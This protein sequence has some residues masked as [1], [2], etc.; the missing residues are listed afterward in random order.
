ML[1]KVDNVKDWLLGTTQGDEMNATFSAFPGL[2]P[3]SG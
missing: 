3:G 2:Y 1:F